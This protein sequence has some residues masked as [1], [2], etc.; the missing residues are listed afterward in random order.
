MGIMVGLPSPSGSEKDLQLN[1]GKNMTVQVEMRAP[2][3]PAE[4][5]L[6]SGI[7]LTWPHAGTD[8]AYMLKEV[9]ECFVN[10]A[11]EIAKRELLLIVTPEPEEVKKQIVATVNMDNV[12]FLRCETNDTWARDHGA[13]TMID[14]GNPSLLDFTFNGWGL[15]FAS[16]LDNLITGQAVKAGDNIVILESMK[17][18]IPVVAPQDGTVASIDVAVGDAIDSGAVL[19]TLN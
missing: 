2:H 3:L 9:Q 4:W 5:H 8:W 7:Q 18:E 1:F 15:K 17:M 14:T 13:I 19:A 12:R 11:R 10:I 16:E 6:Q